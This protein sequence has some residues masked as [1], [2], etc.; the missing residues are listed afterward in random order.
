MEVAA[1]ATGATAE[2][3]AAVTYTVRRGIN[4]YADSH[5]APLRRELSIRH[6]IEPG[7]IVVGNGAAE[8][9][10][11]AAHALLEHGVPVSICCDNSTVSRTNQ[12]IECHKAAEEIGVDAVLQ[13]LKDSEKYTFIKP[14]T[15]LVEAGTD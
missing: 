3:V 9:L 2:V 13:I 5:A 10:A 4:R 15:A 14:E 7:R 12:N 8:L 1:D 6:G 11:A